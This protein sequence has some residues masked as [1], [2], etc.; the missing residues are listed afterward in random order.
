[1]LCEILVF[2]AVL[3]LKPEPLI[4][5]RDNGR[6]EK[7]PKWFL[8]AAGAAEKFKGNLSV[9]DPFMGFLRDRLC[10][11]T[12]GIR[13]KNDSQLRTDGHLDCS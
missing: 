4:L 8:G 7:R 2:P 9:S 10:L 12:G 1:M 6:S 11:C 13:T 3:P 5:Q